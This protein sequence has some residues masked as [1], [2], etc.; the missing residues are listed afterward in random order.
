MYLYPD[1]NTAILGEWKDGR[2]VQGKPATLQSLSIE[3]GLSLH[4]LRDTKYKIDQQLLL[5]ILAK[6]F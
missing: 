3:A 1:I 4:S 2:M 5:I 6:N